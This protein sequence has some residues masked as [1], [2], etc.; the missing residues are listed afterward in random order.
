LQ[1]SFFL[2]GLIV[3]FLVGVPVAFAMGLT[4][5]GL[6]Y[7]NW[8]EIKTG[9][10]SQM[11]L[12]GVNSFV[13]LSVPLFILSGRLMNTGGVSERIF[14]FA[15]SLVGFL[16][17]GLG[18]VNVVASMI[19]SG[20][21]G[22]A[23]ADAVGTGSLEIKAMKDAGYDVRFAAALTATSATIGPIIPPSVPM[24]IYGVVAGV[25]VGSLFLGGIIPGVIMGILMM[26]AVTI[27]A[28]KH[29]FPR[30][31]MLTAREF[32]VNL[33]VAILPMLTPLMIIGG[34]Y[35]GMFTPT[36]AAV[37]AVIYAFILGKFVYRELSWKDIHTALRE[38]VRDSALIGLIIA[39]AA[40]YGNL[41]VRAQIPQMVLESLGSYIT[42]AAMALLILNIFL[43]IIGCFMETLAAITILMPV[44]MP[45]LDKFDI[46]P[47][48]FGVVMVLNLMIGVI[49]PPFGLVLFVIARIA[50]LGIPELVRA[51]LPWY[52]VLIVA[53]IIITIFPQTVLWLPHLLTE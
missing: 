42:S 23:V 45:L 5:F 18:H 14:R 29:N 4:S 1:L 44:I 46:D 27:M 19:F 50:K 40:L 21:T 34:I 47:V 6:M 11:M 39:A 7:L 9:L 52:G 17:G 48:H 25:S 8:G 20:M 13:L 32:G 10:I 28:K 37:V 24:V 31:K 3:L 2:T 26:V 41:V 36:E 15:D 22:T 38:S 35:T 43:L 51:L 30:G 49:T 12:T 33:K 16:P 53:L